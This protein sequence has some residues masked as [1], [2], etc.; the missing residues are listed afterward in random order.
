VAALDRADELGG[1][2]D[3]ALRAGADDLGGVAGRGG[4]GQGG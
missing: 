1:I 3:R 2:Q 4:A